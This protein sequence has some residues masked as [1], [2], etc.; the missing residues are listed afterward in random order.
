MASLVRRLLLSLTLAGCARCDEPPPR[1]AP[2]PS[3]RG[4]GEA[5]IEPASPGAE[6]PTDP[7]AALD[8]PPPIRV[9]VADEAR[10]DEVA[11][12]ALG[13]GG[14]P[15]AVVIL[16]RRSG[17]IFRRAY[18]AMRTE[19]SVEP[20]RVDTIFDLSSVTKLFTTT[21]VL[22]AIEGGE[23]ELGSDVGRWIPALRGATIEQLL[24]HTSGLPA[25]TS[26]APYDLEDRGE[27]LRGVFA[28]AA[29]RRDPPGTYRY[30]DVGFI[31]LGEVLARL[32]AMPL[33]DLVDEKLAAPLGLRDLAYGPRRDDPRVAPTERAPRRAAPGE[34]APIVWGETIDP[35]AWRLDGVAG[36]AGLFASADDL[37]RFAEAMLDG[38]ALRPETLA[39]VTEARELP[40]RGGP[41]RRGLGVDM[42]T[43]PGLSASSF[44]HGGYAGVWLWIDP[45]QDL[46]V[47]VATHRV[48]PDGEGRAG[49]L[50]AQV[51]RIASEARARAL[52][53]MEGGPALGIDVLRSAGFAPLAGRRIALLTHAAAVARDGRRTVELLRETD[54][55]TLVRIFTPEH[56]LQGD[57]EGHVGDGML[58]EI[59]LVSLF[60]RRRDPPEGS[61]ADVDVLVVDL[62]D[63]GARFY[64]YFATMHRLLVAAAEA[65]VPVWVLDRPNPQG[66]QVAGWVST[67]EA[68]SFVNHSPLP[69]LHGLTAA[70]MAALLRARN[71]LTVELHPIPMAGWD[72]EPWPAAGLRWVPPSPNLPSLD[73]VA[74]YPGLALVEGANVAVGRGTDEPFQRLGAPWLDPEALLAALPPE[75]MRGVRVDAE[76]FTPTASRHRGQRI[77]GLRFAVT[78][79]AA[80]QPVRLGLA[81]LRGLAHAPGGGLVLSETGGMVADPELLGAIESGASQEALEAHGTGILAEFVRSRRAVLMYED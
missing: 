11:R 67:A 61:L 43:P 79:R 78:D 4:A 44:G 57:A 45:A 47:V 52:P 48:H 7:L 68:R 72:G 59:P 55:L 63:V 69:V 60:G 49:P 77:P 26:L 31:A 64:T 75:A 10:L 73:A 18:G 80:V 66:R 39:T 5:A 13:A 2:D 29:G 12:R 81:I 24:T 21:L 51:A 9:T 41:V 62:Q 20:M 76:S 28:E 71:D 54:A 53:P 30:S 14:V 22:Q 16:G 36:H 38:R 74:L 1:S 27:A 32:H 42:E 8:L 37:A 65:S 3:A 19:P 50:R 23:L 70:E 15:G 6:G 34:A 46:Y 58:G 17:P 56:G 35:R 25:V 33:E 40:S